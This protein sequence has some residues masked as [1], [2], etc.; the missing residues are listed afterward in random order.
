MLRPEHRRGGPAESHDPARDLVPNPFRDRGRDQ[1]QDQNQ[2]QNPDQDP[3]Q[4][5]SR[6]HAHAPVPVPVPVLVPVPVP[7][8]HPN[9]DHRLDRAR[10]L[11]RVRRL[12]RA[13]SPDLG[14]AV[15]N[16]GTRQDLDPSRNR[17]RE[18]LRSHRRGLGR[19][20]DPD[21]DQDRNPVAVAVPLARAAK[22]APRASESRSM[23]GNTRLILILPFPS[24]ILTS[25][26][27]YRCY[28]RIFR[29]V[30]PVNIRIIAYRSEQK[31]IL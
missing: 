20:R 30:I 12:N 10:V 2:N 29:I 7:V 18:R 21:R 9:L 13:V 1:D 16:R 27:L 6:V 26:P 23:I 3:N 28:L 25:I 19:A 24:I 17:A 15:L 4:D 22:A 5:R 14:L 8:H 11:S 31:L